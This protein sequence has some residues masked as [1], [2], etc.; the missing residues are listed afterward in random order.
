MLLEGN[1]SC[2]AL[3][4]PNPEG[5]QKSNRIPQTSITATNRIKG[6]SHQFERCI[7]IDLYEHC[8]IILNNAQYGFRRRRSAVLQLVIYIEHLYKSVK[9]GTEFEVV[10]TDFEKAFD[11]VDHGVI[12]RKLWQMGVIGKLWMKIKSYLQN[13]RQVVKVGNSF[14]KRVCMTSGLPQG[15]MDSA[16]F[17]I[18]LEKFC[19]WCLRNVAI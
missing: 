9:Q 18:D 5:R 11:K 8:S 7:F 15:R 1:I 4:S 13:R 3:F 14:S 10:Y 12:L 17:Q 2:I 16:L 6:K 19:G